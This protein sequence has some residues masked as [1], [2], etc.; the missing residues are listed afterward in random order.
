MWLTLQNSGSGPYYSGATASEILVSREERRIKLGYKSL[1]E[2]VNY[3]DKS[4]KN[5]FVL[6]HMDERSLGLL[7]DYLKEYDE[8]YWQRSSEE[9]EIQ[10]HLGM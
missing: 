8:G 5:Q 4:L 10:L 9:L 3:M 1:P 6:S 2:H 7:R